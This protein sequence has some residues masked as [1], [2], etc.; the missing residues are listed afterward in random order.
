ISLHLKSG[1]HPASMRT[2][3]AQFKIIKDTILDLK[4]KT[5]VQDFFFAGDLNTTEYTNKGADY[6]ALTRMVSELN[7][8]DLSAN[9]QCSAYWWGGTDDGIE[10]PTLLDHV[11]V[12]PGLVKIRG[13]KT[14]V[15]GHCKKVS[16][17]SATPRELG[18]SYES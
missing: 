15:A 1:S 11:I 14:S 2:R 12:T 18:I 3:H 16:C 9:E 10:A 6:K 8:I 17:Q 13:A 4:K 5:G 7:M